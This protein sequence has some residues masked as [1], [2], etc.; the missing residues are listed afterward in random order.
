[1]KLKK[2]ASLMLAGIM[3]VSMLA[4]CKGESNSN[5]T[6]NQPETPAVS[7]VAD[8]ANY[9]LSGPQKDVFTFKDSSDLST[10]LKN[11]AE[12]VDKFTDNSIEYVYGQAGVITAGTTNLAELLGKVK[13]N[14]GTR[15]LVDD[16]ATDA[17]KAGNRSM[18]SVYSVSGK[19]GEEEAVKSAVNSFVSG[20]TFSTDYPAD[21]TGYNYEYSAEIS[22]VNVASRQHPTKSAWVIAIVVTQTATVAA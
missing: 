11:A 17:T 2:I 20:A 19:V 10:A 8:Y 6:P 5:S 21:G 9:M 15:A 3:A 14:L 13:E 22:S 12:N 7:K 4:G 18:V 16:F 1:M